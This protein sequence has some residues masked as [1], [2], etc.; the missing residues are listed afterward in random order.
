MCSQ[1]ICFSW[2]EKGVS[3][4]DNG[5]KKPRKQKDKEV[6]KRHLGICCF[7]ICIHAFWCLVS[8]REQHMTLGRCTNKRTAALACTKPKGRLSNPWQRCN[9]L[10]NEYFHCA[11]KTQTKRC[12]YTTCVKH[13]TRSGPVK[14]RSWAKFNPP[15]TA[16]NGPVWIE[17][18]TPDLNH[19][20][21]TIQYT[22][23]FVIIFFPVSLCQSTK[24]ALF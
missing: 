14:V 3:D 10:R 1:I 5:K 6:N 22:L 8:L 19:R 16:L 13:R 18:E 2:H 23:R 12:S 21:F 20:R 11:L 9:L 15:Q 17:F 4:F 24:V 7:S